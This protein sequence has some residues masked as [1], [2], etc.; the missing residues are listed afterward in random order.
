MDSISLALL[1][2]IS[3][4]GLSVVSPT[5]PLYVAHFGVSYAAIGGFFSAYSLTWALFQVYTGHLSD[6]YGRKRFILAGLLWYGLSA[7]GCALARS[8]AQ[9]LLFRILQGVGL[10]LFG[11]AMLGVAAGFEDKS[12]AFALYRSAQTAGSTVAPLVGGTIGRIGLGYPFLIS[13]AVSVLAMGAVLPLQMEQPRGERGARFWPSMQALFSRRDFLL[14]CLGTFLAELGYVALNVALPLAGGERG[15][16]T[17]AIGLV[18]AG[19]SVAFVLSQVPLGLLA[20]RWD[21]RSLLV[22][23][24]GLAALA[25][26]GLFVA[27][28]AWQMGVSTILLGTTLGTIFVQSGAWAAELAP[29]AQKSFYMAAFDSVI[30]LSFVIM[31]ILVGVIAGWDVGGPFLAC[32]LLLVAS[33]AILAITPRCSLEG[34][35]AVADSG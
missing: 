15:L 10:G 16:S 29:S 33:A 24:G 26:A 4:F 9:L 31:P 32:S 6:R 13:G 8:F 27:R 21:R 22:L 30:D 23:C 18:M 35:L 28:Q 12:R 34:R 7:L 3:S 19:Y 25:F 1:A 20:E 11:P 2:F 14:L 17:E 5:L